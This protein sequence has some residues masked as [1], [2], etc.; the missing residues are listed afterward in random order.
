MPPNITPALRDHII[1]DRADGRCECLGECG[2]SHKFGVHH[3]CPHRHG[4]PTVH[5]IK[6]TVM[7]AVR[8]LDGDTKNTTNTNLLAMCQACIKRHRR[9]TTQRAARRAEQAA[10]DAMHVDALFDLDD[11]TPAPPPPG[12]HP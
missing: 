1:I 9:L 7:L 4:R 11:P 6:T 12:A 10:I 3:R 2:R 5:G 8:H